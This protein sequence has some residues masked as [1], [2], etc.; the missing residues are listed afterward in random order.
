[1]L[2]SLS[3][4][5]S[6]RDVVLVFQCLERHVICLE[7]FRH[8]CQVRVNERQFVYDPAIGYSLPCAG[9]LTKTIR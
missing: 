8:Y 4:S 1:M 7:C 9:E 6:L 5:L 2:Q 3:L